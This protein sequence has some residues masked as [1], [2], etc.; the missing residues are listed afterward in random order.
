MRLSLQWGSRRLWFALAMVA[1]ATLHVFARDSAADGTIL[2]TASTDYTGA[3][4]NANGTYGYSYPND[5]SN[6]NPNIPAISAGVTLSQAS[7]GFDGNVVGPLPD[8]STYGPFGYNAN[9]GGSTGWVTASY[10]LPTSGSFQL[11]W[12]VAN[13]V[14]CAG[15]DALATDNITLNGNQLFNFQ[16]GGLPTGFT[17]LGNFGTSA[18]VPDLA[19][20]AGAAFAFMDVQPPPSS[21]NVAPI[22]DTV[23]GY[24]ASRIYS[25]TFIAG[26]GDTLSVDAAFLTSDGSPYAD[27]G[28]VALFSVP[29]PASLILGV[30]G[31]CGV[32]GIAITRASRC[33]GSIASTARLA[34]SSSAQRSCSL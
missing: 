7:G 31:V 32:A 18:V 16:P 15:A 13:V 4:Q 1:C 24:S 26:A 2:F 14:N 10:T 33:L 9:A 5:P 20:S 28:I 8:G 30:W 25:A 27:Y 6:Q 29:E 22:F 21:T 3:V 23:D 17:G 34:S 11:V 19:P 12:E